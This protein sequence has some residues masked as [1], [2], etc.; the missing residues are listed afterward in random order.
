MKTTTE[1]K[2]LTVFLEGRIDTNN[3]AQTES[4]IFAAVDGVSGADIIIDAEKL[5]YISSAGL[6]VLLKAQKSKNIPITI[7]N[8]SRDVY[9]IFD[10][11]GFVDLLDEKGAPQGEY[12]GYDAYRQRF[13]R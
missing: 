11:T 8:V 6:R 7:S 13:Y 5:E 9:D 2:T 10:T 12:R 1:N 3:A 4:E